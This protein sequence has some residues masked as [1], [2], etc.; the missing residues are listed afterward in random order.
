MSRS[1]AFGI[2]QLVD[3]ADALSERHLPAT[4]TEWLAQSPGGLH[5]LARGVRN[6]EVPDPARSQGGQ[7]PADRALPDRADRPVLPRSV[8]GEMQRR[9]TEPKQV[10]VTLADDEHRL[11]IRQQAIQ[12]SSDRG[13]QRI[14]HSSAVGA[15]LL[16][17]TRRRNRGLGRGDASA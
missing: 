10:V 15:S 11:A 17:H 7:L 3:R 9:P 16:A 6:E 4:L 1:V 5:L 14:L 2:F 13:P 8:I 12:E